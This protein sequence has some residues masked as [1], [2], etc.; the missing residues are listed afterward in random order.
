[1]SGEFFFSRLAGRIR[2]YLLKSYGYEKWNESSKIF[3]DPWCDSYV[4]SVFM[5]FCSIFSTTYPF[6]SFDYHTSQFIFMASI[7]HKFRI[8]FFQIFTNFLTNQIVLTK[9]QQQTNRKTDRN[10][11]FN[12]EFS[13]WFKM[14]FH[15]FGFV[16]GPN[17]SD[18]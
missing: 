4:S 5:Q 15:N 2:K 7:R 10:L 14:F 13:S 18:I 8:S 17:R 9:K 6:A 1:M 11:D 16:V 3:L 12:P